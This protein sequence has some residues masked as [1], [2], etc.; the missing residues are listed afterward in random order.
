MVP[1]SFQIFHCFGLELDQLVGSIHIRTRSDSIV[2]NLLKNVKCGSRIYASQFRKSSEGH[3][4]RSEWRRVRSLSLDRGCICIIGSS[5]T[6]DRL[7]EIC[8][9]MVRSRKSRVVDETIVYNRRFQI[10]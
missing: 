9:L 3:F 8:M 10:S 7:C 2:L 5:A 4:V 6:S 1:Q